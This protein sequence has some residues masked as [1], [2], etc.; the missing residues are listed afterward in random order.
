MS[1][2]QNYTGNYAPINGLNLY[3]EI[4]GTGE[5]L[6]LLHGAY[7]NTN[8]MQPLLSDLAR[9]RQVIALDF[10]A[11]GRT[12]DIDRPLRMESLAGDVAALLQFLNIPQA[13]IFGYSLGGGVAVQVA[14]RYPQLVRKLVA[15]SVSFNVAGMYP[16]LMGAMDNI[17]PEVFEGTPTKTEYDKVAPNPADFPKLVE[18]LKDLDTAIYDWPAES[19]KSIKAPTFLFIGDSDIVRPEHIVDMFRLL[20]GGVAG[21]LVGLPN[22]RLAILPGTTHVTVMNRSEWIVPMVEEFL[23]LPL[24]AQA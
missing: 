15:A 11:H 3:Y 4:H 1:A 12:A 16:E 19:I 21:D 5:P 23:N 13:D 8:A 20:G 7:M 14:V 9:T 10:Q 24:P 18:K 22:A 2:E 6:V 17:T